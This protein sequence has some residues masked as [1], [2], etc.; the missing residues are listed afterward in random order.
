M[1]LWVASV[2]VSTRFLVLA[3]TE[4]GATQI[5]HDEGVDRIFDTPLVREVALVEDPTQLVPEG[6]EPDFIISHRIKGE[7]T[8][9][10]VRATQMAVESAEEDARK[11]F[12]DAE[13]L[14][15]QIPLF[16]SEP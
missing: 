12:N 7:G 10:L 6:W 1:R 2:K 9:K 15:L 11:A 5:V 16:P 14:R 4:G 3:E 13:M 8:I